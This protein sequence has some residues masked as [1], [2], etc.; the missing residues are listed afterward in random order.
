MKN[1]SSQTTQFEYSIIDY[2]P[3][4][5]IIVV[6]RDD[7]L[8]S[9]H[10]RFKTEAAPLWVFND[11]NEVVQIILEGKIAYKHKNALPW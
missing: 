8:Y 11:E 10:S 9:I 4:S 3:K 5:G 7:K 6:L 1:S 2:R